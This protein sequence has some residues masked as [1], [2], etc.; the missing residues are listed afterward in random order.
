MCGLFLVGFL[1]IE[2]QRGVNVF[3]EIFLLI[4]DG[5]LHQDKEN[6]ERDSEKIPTQL[7]NKEG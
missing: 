3:K 2:L 7:K 6:I 1:K 5:C 4:F